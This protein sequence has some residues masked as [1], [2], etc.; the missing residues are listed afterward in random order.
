MRSSC[1]VT[2][3]PYT[4]SPAPPSSSTVGAQN[5]PSAPLCSTVPTAQPSR[6]WPSSSTVRS[7]P[8]N[9]TVDENLPRLVTATN[10]QS[11]LR[12]PQQPPNSLLVLG[13]SSSK[14]LIIIFDLIVLE[15]F[16]I[17]WLVFN[18]NLRKRRR[19]KIKKKNKEE[20]ENVSRSFRLVKGGV[21]LP[22][23]DFPKLG[24]VKLWAQVELKIHWVGLRQI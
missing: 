5:R 7:L 14:I 11:S 24:Q 9:C 8:F 2:R 13:F 19:S 17:L 10:L 4:P 3:Q 12:L 16:A 22:I 20:K 15:W 6:I 18:R 1:P 23:L 21:W